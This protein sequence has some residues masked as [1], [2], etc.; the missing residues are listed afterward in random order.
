METNSENGGTLADVEAAGAAGRRAALPWWLIALEVLVVAGVWS[1]LYGGEQTW[2]NIGLTVAVFAVPAAV[3][4]VVAKRRGRAGELASGSRASVVH[5]S[6]FFGA[7]IAGMISTKYL[8]AGR[9]LTY[10]AV[11]L[12]VV[13]L[14]G[15]C[16]V[17]AERIALRRPS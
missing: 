16:R 7:M 14:Y 10:A 1:M 5:L 11:F 13:V 8:E 17:A 15:G 3:L 12:I 2:R 9:P 6:G 4:V